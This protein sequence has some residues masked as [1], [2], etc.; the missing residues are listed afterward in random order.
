[1]HK[2]LNNL[3]KTRIAFSGPFHNRKMRQV[4]LLGLFTEMTN[5][6]TLS[7]VSTIEFPALFIYLEIENAA[8]SVQASIPPRAFYP[9]T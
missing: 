2:Y 6:L 8:F 4:A 3:R 5:F 9:G 1:M 7:Y